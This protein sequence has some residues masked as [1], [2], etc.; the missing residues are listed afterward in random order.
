MILFVLTFFTLYGGVHVYAFF[1]ARAALGFGAETGAALA[2][3]MLVMTMAPFLIRF[4]ERHG[5]E[6][7]ARALS[8]IAYLWMAALFLFFCASLVSDILNLLTRAV[9]WAASA[10]ITPFLLSRKTSFFLCLGLSLAICIYGYF[11]ALNIRTERL[12]IETTKLPRGID[13]LTI[14]QLS[15]VHLGLIVRCSRMGKMLDLVK[16]AKPDILVSTGDLVDAEINHLTGLAE[17]LREVN[18]RYGKFAITGNHEYFAGLDKALAFTK[19]AGFTLLRGEAAADG[20]INIAGVND[21]QGVRMKLDQPVSEKALLSK[22][23]KDKFTLFLKHQPLVDP[24]TEGLFDLQLSGHTHKGQIFPF[25]YVSALAYPMN[26]GRYDLPKGSILY[27]SRGSGTWGPPVRF[28]SSPQI[29][30]VE[31]VR[32]ENNQ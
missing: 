2:V 18:P 25:A 28:L 14:V 4:T 30:V 24:E 1:R 7:T 5:Y 9:S 12:R 22:L 3:F 10:D 20:V 23:S 16:A 26:A 32:K 31:L 17:L 11:D 6:L 13:R 15:D 29:T 21:L 8:Y 27:V 19:M